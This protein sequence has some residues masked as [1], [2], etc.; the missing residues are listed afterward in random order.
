MTFV[1]EWA[2]SFK[3]LE[4]TDYQTDYVTKLLNKAMNL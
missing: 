4:A 3:I 1:A 2:A